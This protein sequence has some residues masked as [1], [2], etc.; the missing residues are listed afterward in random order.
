M[1]NSRE[2]AAK[3]RGAKEKERQSAHLSHRNPWRRRAYRERGRNAARCSSCA[4][5]PHPPR[6]LLPGEAP[7]RRGLGNS[8]PAFEAL[9]SSRERETWCAKG[10]QERPGENGEP[11]KPK[12]TGSRSRG[13]C[14]HLLRR[15]GGIGVGI[16]LG[17]PPV[18]RQQRAGADD[19]G[20]AARMPGH[21]R[22]RLRVTLRCGG[23]AGLA[24]APL[25]Q[26]QRSAGAG[27]RR[28]V[29]T[30]AARAAAADGKKA[31]AAAGQSSGGLRTETV[32]T[33]S[34]VSMATILRPSPQEHATRSS[35]LR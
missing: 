10:R 12:K 31:A 19:E 7:P 23:G 29:S 9:E 28:A 5:P 4:G 2:T 24:A 25:R 18:P 11:S 1:K 35:A 34:P 13:Y 8:W 6:P 20:L 32:A 15:A 16:R 33:T 26:L 14:T 21:G 17:Q 22:H 27:A 3:H 30:A